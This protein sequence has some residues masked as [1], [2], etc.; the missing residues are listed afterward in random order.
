MKIIFAADMSFNYLPKFPGVEAANACMKEAGALMASADFSMLNLENIFG[1]AENNI[2]LTKNGPNLISSPDF[3]AY[4]HALHPTVVGL[5][6]NHTKDYGEG[7]MTFTKELL[8]KDGYVCIGAG[9]NLEDAY[10][11]AILEKDGTRVAIVAVCENEFGTADEQTSGTAG[12]RLSM[13]SHLIADAKN[14]GALPII[15]FHGGHETYPYPSPARQELYR[16]F[17]ELGAAAVICMHTHCPQGYEIYQGAPIV[18]SMGNLFFPNFPGMSETSSWYYGYMSELVIENGNVSLLTHPYRFDTNAIYLLK[19]TEKD[20]FDAYMAYIN[21]PIASAQAL[22]DLFDS[23]CLVPSRFGYYQ[24]LTSFD[25]ELLAD[26]ND[27][28]ITA[29]KNVFGCEA[30]NELVKNMLFMIYENRVEA[31]RAGV[32]KILTLQK[33]QIPSEN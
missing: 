19:G 21:K 11:P 20:A 27:K 16:H 2:P 24:S 12:Y 32:E 15:Y 17:V 13:V 8:E 33:M 29:L 31:A 25:M 14:N 3:A 10:R 18:Y 26:G 5:A 6:N 4:V 30:H 23:W 7:P 1:V 28:K 9:K 22:R